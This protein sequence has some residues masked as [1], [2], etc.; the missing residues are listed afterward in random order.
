MILKITDSNEDYSMNIYKLSLFEFGQKEYHP[1]IATQKWDIVEIDLNENTP[2]G[3]IRQLVKNVIVRPIFDKTNIT[4]RVMQL[5]CE[6]VPDSAGELRA[7]FLKDKTKF[8]VIVKEL[9]ERYGW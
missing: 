5:L 9:S 4:V 8:Y 1:F 7:S 6:I 2:R 3:I